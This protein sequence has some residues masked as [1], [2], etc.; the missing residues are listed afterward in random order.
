MEIEKQTTTQREA[1]LWEKYGELNNK[2]IISMKELDGLMN[3]VE[4]LLMNYKDTVESRDKFK[5]EVKRL[6]IKI[7]EME[8]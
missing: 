7:K 8:K 5:E 6:N 2:Q 1:D 4:K 3:A